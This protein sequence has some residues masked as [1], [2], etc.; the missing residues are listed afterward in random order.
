M[1]RYYDKSWQPLEDVFD[2]GRLFEDP[3]YKRVASDT[4]DY[5]THVSTVWLWLDHNLSSDW[6]PVIFETMI[7]SKHNELDQ[8]TARYSTIDEA[9]KRVC[10][11]ICQVNLKK[12]DWIIYF[13]S[14]YYNHAK[15]R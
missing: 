4:F 15:T 7:F 3:E 11:W 2:W 13:N 5:E 6:P 14:L 12:R 9:K 10:L 8:F 1:I